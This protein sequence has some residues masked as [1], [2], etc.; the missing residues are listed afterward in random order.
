MPLKF[1]QLRLP[2]LAAWTPFV[3]LNIC[4]IFFVQICKSVS[5]MMKLKLVKGTCPI[6]G[7]SSIS[8]ADVDS[9]RAKC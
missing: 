4:Y 3:L 8:V 2:S 5:R 1:T 9:G 7:P 6:S